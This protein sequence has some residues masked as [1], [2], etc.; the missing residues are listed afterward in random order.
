MTSCALGCRICCEIRSTNFH[1]GGIEPALEGAGNLYENTRS[2]LMWALSTKR[3]KFGLAEPELEDATALAAAARRAMAGWSCS[4]RDLV[5]L[6]DA[7][8][9]SCLP[10]RTSVPIAPWRTGRVTL[11]GDAIHSMTP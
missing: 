4:L 9:I 8:T 11:L 1:I 7:S 6:T 3:E 2:Y 10:I 5:G